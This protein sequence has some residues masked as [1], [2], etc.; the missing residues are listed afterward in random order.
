MR[1]KLPFLGALLAFVLGGCG[2]YY[3]G[4]VTRR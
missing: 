2:G 1:E 3:M 4:T